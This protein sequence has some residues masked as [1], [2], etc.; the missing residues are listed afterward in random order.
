MPRGNRRNPRQA[1]ERHEK[2]TSAG[3]SSE[4]S[5]LGCRSGYF[6]PSGPVGVVR[7]NR[8][9]PGGCLVLILVLAFH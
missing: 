9:R 5:A 4:L 2:K 3:Q 1:G 6:P 8:F 7:W